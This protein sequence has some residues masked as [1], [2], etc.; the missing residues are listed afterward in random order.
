MG[1]VEEAFEGYTLEIV[2]PGLRVSDVETLSL[3]ESAKNRNKN[4]TENPSLAAFRYAGQELA[5][6]RQLYFGS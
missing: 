6:L 2:S 4:T 5:A 3:Q 1:E